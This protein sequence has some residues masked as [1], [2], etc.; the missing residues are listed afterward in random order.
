MENREY[1][2]VSLIKGPASWYGDQGQETVESE[3]VQVTFRNSG[4]GSN[5]TSVVRGQFP[6]LF[7]G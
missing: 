6:T 2:L 3:G 1:E 4:A 5:G 7:I